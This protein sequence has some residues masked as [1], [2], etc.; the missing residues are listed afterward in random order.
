VLV[1]GNDS[2]S[3][4]TRTSVA[5]VQRYVLEGHDAC[6][7]DHPNDKA[8][9]ILADL[10]RAIFGDMQR[11]GQVLGGLAKAVRYKGRSIGPREDGAAVVAAGIS[12]DVEFVEDLTQP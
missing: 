12:I 3:D 2:P 5:N 9:D 7:P 4:S 10:K 1:E 8:H 11:A 6:D